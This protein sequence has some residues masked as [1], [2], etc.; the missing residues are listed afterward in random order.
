M[1]HHYQCALTYR[2]AILSGDFYPSWTDS[3]NLGYGSMELRLYPP[4]SHYVLALFSIA[5]SDWHLAT[6]LSYFFWLSLGSFGI[7]LWA[8]EFF[9]Q[10]QAMFASIIYAVMPYKL[11][12][13][14]LVFFYG[15]V[16]G[17]AVI[18]FCFAFLTK[19][20]KEA[21]ETSSSNRE[22]DF[23][24][25]LTPNVLALALSFGILILT[26]LPLT[27]ITSFTLVI[28]ATAN[29]KKKNF[30]QYIFKL[31]VSVAVA[32]LGTSFFW[33]KVLQERSILAK[34]S[35]Y[36]D[37]YLHYYLNFLVTPIQNIEFSATKVY[38]VFTLPYDI[39][40][41]LSLLS[42]IPLS[43]FVLFNKKVMKDQY[44]ISL[45]ITFIAG[46]FL[47]TIF[48]KPIW[49]NFFLLQEVQF[50][51]R[52]LSVV[53]IFGSLVVVSGFDK[54]HKILKNPNK[55]RPLALITSGIMMICITF[56]I[57]TAVRGAIYTPGDEISDYVKGLTQVEG[58]RF[59]WTIW[60]KDEFL[61]QNYEKVFSDKDIQIYKWEATKKIFTVK[62]VL[63]NNSEIKVGIFYHPNWKCSVNG[64]FVNT[65]YSKEGLMLITIAEKSALV[66]LNFEE[67][68][69]VKTSKIISL[70]TIV[71]MIFFCSILR[72]DFWQNRYYQF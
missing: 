25:I 24:Q 69:L 3:R 30:K 27:L 16:A 32:L 49:D 52:W 44:F 72:K 6:W 8:K 33:T 40:L 62:S 9:S 63:E 28:Y 12:Q 39:I 68:F 48:S 20:I 1:P 70:F 65:G 13:M 34:T 43:L 42:T 67:S 53:S 31:I 26:H 38:D 14:Y 11:N 66:E 7:Y 60:T 45:Y 18:P 4:I 55:Y 10:N 37:I 15:E 23:K 35:V 2:E 61:K 47:T 17:M 21:D 71:C 64:K 41:L 59:W 36:E 54:L 58:F 57:S 50:P 51:W 22:I 46:V 56:S 29:L 5:V 19:I